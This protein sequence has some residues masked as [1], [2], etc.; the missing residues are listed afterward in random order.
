MKTL[1]KIKTVTLNFLLR[2]IE[3]LFFFEVMAVP[4]L[5]WMN[6]KQT[7]I[8]PLKLLLGY[9]ILLIIA[10]CVAGIIINALNK[11]KK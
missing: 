10:T 1:I 11:E 6:D 3:V 8:I 7:E 4:I 9:D 5:L 2:A